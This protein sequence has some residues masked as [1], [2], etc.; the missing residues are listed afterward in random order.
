MRSDTRFTLLK[1]PDVRSRARSLLLVACIAALAL[2]AGMPAFA[3]CNPSFDPN[4]GELAGEGPDV[5]F[6]PD[7]GTYTVGGPSTTIPVETV[8]TD[9]DLPNPATLQV[10]I[11]TAGTARTLNLTWTTS[12]DGSRG[13]AKGSFDLFGYGDHVL[14]A[15]IADGLGNIG[16]S[17]TTFTLKAIV[18]G[19][20]VVK[21]GLQHDDYRNT[22]GG[23][24]MLAYPGWSYSSMGT[25][26]TTGLIYISELARPTA[27]Y[28]VDAYETADAVTALSLR[29]E[30]QNNGALVVPEVFYDNGDGVQRLGAWWWWSASSPTGIAKL[31]AV[32]RSYKSDQTYKE[33]RTPVRLLLQSEAASRYGAGWIVAGIKRLHGIGTDGVLMTE[34]DGVVRFF[35]RS[36]PTPTTCTYLTPQ[37]DFSQ[38]VQATGGTWLR[39]YPDGGKVTFSAAGLMTSSIDRLGNATTVE[40]QTAQDGTNT[41]VLSRIVDPVGQVTTFAYDAA[42]Y[43]KSINS[44]GGRTVSVTLDSTSKAI[45]AI[46]GPT[47]LRLTYASGLVSSFNVSH[48]ATD[49]GVTTDVTYDDALRLRT[50]T[51]AA[52]TVNGQSV[53]P[54]TIYRAVDLTVVPHEYWV[55]TN[56]NFANPADAV[57]SDAV[58]AELTDAGGHV[59]KLASDRY[60]SP[61]KIIDA[62]GNITTIGWT[63]DGLLERVIGPAEARTNIWDAKGRL[64]QSMLDGVAVYEA[65]YDVGGRLE[66]E[67]NGKSG[68][69]YEHGSR[70][71]VTRT[72]Y[73]KRGD[74]NRTGTRFEYNGRYQVTAAVDPKGGRTEWSYENNAWKNPDD[75]R[76][77]RDDGVILTTRFTYDGA[78]RLRTVEN[79]LG[80]VTTTEYDSLDRTSQILDPAGRSTWYQYTGPHM[81]KVIDTA[82]KAYDFA[83]NALGWLESESF[84]DGGTRTYRYDRE[85]LLTGTTN[86]RG[87][88]LT[89][90]YD[91]LHR[92][93]SRT[94]DGAVT[95][96][97]YPDLFT[98]VV[99]NLEST[100]T[101]KSNADTHVPDGVSATLGGKRFEI[102]RV[103]DAADAR[104]DI[105]FDLL[106][107]NGSTLVRTNEMRYQLNYL[108]SDVTLGITNELKDFSA[109]TSTIHFDTAGR[110]V[111]IT[112][113]NGLT[114]TQAFANDGRLNAVTFSNALVNQKLGGTFAYELLDRL[115][116]RTSI[117]EDR[118]W[119][120]AY[121]SVGQL[122]SYGAYTNPPE[123]CIGLACAPAVI[124]SESYT[125]DAAGNRTDRGGLVTPGTNRYT[126]FNGFNFDYDADGNLK[127]KYKAG[128]D[129]RMTWDT[130]GRLTG[131]T[132]N[133]AA[134]SYGYDGL[135]RRVRRTENGQHRYF[136][137]DGDDLLL[138]ADAN[139]EPLRLYTH[140]P[141]TDTPHSVRI[142][143]GG[144][145]STYFYV[146]ELPGH[147]TG[148][149]NEAGNVAAEYR[150]TPFGE[151]ESANDP[152]G[153]PLRFMAR[154]LDSATGLYYV[155]ARWYDPGMGRFVSQDPIGLAGG[156]NPYAYAGND[157]MSMRDPSGLGPKC[158]LNPVNNQCRNIVFLPP[159]S[160]DPR[161]WTHDPN[162]IW[163]A[164]SWDPSPSAVDCYGGGPDPEDVCRGTGIFKMNEE[165]RQELRRASRARCRATR[166]EPTYGEEL[167]HEA[168]WSAVFTIGGAILGS[169]IPGPGT[170][171]GA[172]AG[173][174]IGAL[175]LNIIGEAV[176]E[177]GVDRLFDKCG[178]GLF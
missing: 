87:G 33:T 16:S 116:T 163:Q 69:W 118:Y 167:F 89:R 106:T 135:G 129:Q 97:S 28:Q 146:L 102:K 72:W 166:P 142:T 101:V 136:L 168:K 159:I 126:Q 25:P 169:V 161:S 27:F 65:S 95:T 164:A 4:C 92:P 35:P 20:P 10:K 38:L 111:R 67:M 110:P 66:F 60:G 147:V 74:A 83:Y 56:Q 29:L 153:Q 34:G 170:A 36:C 13:T 64:L 121:D 149:V 151:I 53:R 61:A 113:P 156:M 137:Y 148:L 77:I 143:N 115:N 94:A 82:G 99:T 9:P 133:G 19:E 172:I 46:T 128:F 70:G 50:V 6:L 32:V 21:N 68:A 174:T 88:L 108:P 5:G 18:P 145:S 177:S 132:T 11:W 112:L 44:P 15:Q 134:V 93:A 76:V 90:T 30:R 138:E 158:D 100:V 141:G 40:W 123:N 62:L 140:W 2:F 80:Q 144:V 26:R 150:Y 175:A 173:G 57:L 73:G 154:E 3:Q 155:R 42:W 7:G 55:A 48:G 178:A 119:A 58:F 171:A 81:T 49:P 41:P 127:R 96:L 86:R 75:Q 59:T 122:T 31:T 23:R 22:A 43:L 45:T 79:P 52:V 47:N 105:G 103:Y 130:L 8:F 162:E 91:V 12:F 63:A 39:S 54:Q 120:Y 165:E 131:V 117:N 107:W 14:V 125:Y 78:S 98:T 152:T 139:A 104:R 124:R 85:G 160:S 114:Q 1:P 109:R 51:A 17:R 176:I 24:L 37:G 71:E 157:P 84:P